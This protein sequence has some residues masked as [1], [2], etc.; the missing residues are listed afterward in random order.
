MHTDIHLPEANRR[1]KKYIKKIAF[2][3]I[4]TVH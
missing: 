3:Q 1:N 4:E 2:I